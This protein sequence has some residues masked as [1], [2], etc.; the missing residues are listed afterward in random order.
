M[1]KPEVITGVIHLLSKTE[2][3]STVISNTVKAC[4]Y[5][6]LNFDFVSGP[7]SITMLIKMI[8]LIDYYEKKQPGGNMNLQDLICCISNLL[9]S[10]Q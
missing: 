9:R 2:N 5:L 7:T 1:V 4:T 3:L 8:P 10:S 6:T